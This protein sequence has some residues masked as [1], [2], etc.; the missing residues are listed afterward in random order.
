MASATTAPRIAIVGAG[1]GGLLAARVLQ[2][3][4]LTSTVYDADGSASE[5]NPG[6]TL[7]LHADSGQIAI[8][9]AGLT[10]QFAE[11]ARPE[12]QDKRL[13]DPASGAVL[14]EFGAEPGMFAAP[15]IDRAQLRELLAD[16]VD[17]SRIRWGHKLIEVQPAADNGWRLLFADGSVEEADLVIGADGAWSR[18]R[19][20]LTPAQ[21]RYT[22]VSFVELLFT[23]VDA[24]H[25]DIAD[26]VGEGHLWAN[27]DGQNLI[28]QRNSGGVVRGYLGMRVPLDWLAQAGLGAHDGRGGIELDSNGVQALDTGK[29]RALLRRR[30]ASFAP[31]LRHVIVA[32]EGAFAN[33][34][35]F[36]LPAP[37]TWDHRP[38]VTLIGDA[39][40]V[41]SPFGGN[42]VNFALLDAAEVT[43][44]ILS[45]L[46]VGGDIDAGVREYEAVMFART[47]EVAVRANE[48]IADHYK[49]GGIDVDSVPD[50]VEEHERWNAN[51]EA[52]LRPRATLL[53]AVCPQKQEERHGDDGHDKF[54]NG[55]HSSAS[56]SQ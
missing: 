37:L 5:R 38:G 7:D 23:D 1:P 49:A 24:S 56:R 46:R 41:M 3:G 18:V 50:F 33:R 20:V 44:A 34:P 22:G 9:D 42:G 43:R 25:A 40:H 27:G 32:S 31:A 52:Y 54:N 55:E 6:G 14:K 45:A 36:A 30:F 4:G 39:A 15:E 2:E 17:S 13:V 16:S 10:E 12:G 19:P 53:P 8:D 48:A 47:G 28:L 51:A 26:L 21:P 29:V 11:L 35:I